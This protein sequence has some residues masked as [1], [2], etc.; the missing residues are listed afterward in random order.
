MHFFSYKS[1]F[2]F[3]KAKTCVGTCVCSICVYHCMPQILEKILKKIDSF[4]KATVY[5][6]CYNF[7][8]S[9]VT[10]HRRLKDPLKYVC[11]KIYCLY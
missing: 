2:A 8:W 1:I 3:G 7:D 10:K 6:H 5:A 11:I 4:I 9:Q